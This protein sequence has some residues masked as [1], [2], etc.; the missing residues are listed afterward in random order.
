MVA[1]VTATIVVYGRRAQP[2]PHSARVAAR[3][4][5]LGYAVPGTVVAV[6]V[7]VPLAWLDRRLADSA[8]AVLGSTSA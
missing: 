3:V 2:V 5:T 7:Y 1:V 8:D 6:A 4:T